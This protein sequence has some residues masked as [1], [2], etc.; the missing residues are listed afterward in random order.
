MS[1]WSHGADIPRYAEPTGNF[2]KDV[3]GPSEVCALNILLKGVSYPRTK[4]NLINK[5]NNNIDI[6]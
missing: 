1:H 2:D 4:E 5:E 3:L 6:I